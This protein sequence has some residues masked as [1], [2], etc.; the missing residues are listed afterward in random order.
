MQSLM[1][2]GAVAVG[3]PRREVWSQPAGGGIG[4][5]CTSGKMLLRSISVALRDSGGR[6]T[7]MRRILQGGFANA[8]GFAV[9]RQPLGR[10]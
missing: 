1:G 7:S 3:R 9:F 8:A 10:T 6:F 2:L 4:G 5:D